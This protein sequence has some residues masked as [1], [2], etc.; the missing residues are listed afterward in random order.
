MLVAIQ[1]ESDVVNPPSYDIGDIGLRM[2]ISLRCYDTVN[3][4]TNQVQYT[5]RLGLIF[6]SLG[7]EEKTLAGLS[8]VGGVGMGH[9]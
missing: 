5:L 1:L 7:E 8:S 6:R 2:P 9:V 4:Y 3:I